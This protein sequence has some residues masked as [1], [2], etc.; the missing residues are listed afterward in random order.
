M[1]RSVFAPPGVP[2]DRV[3]AL[4]TALIETVKDPAYVADAKRLALDTTTWQTG[5]AVERVVNDAFS[6]SPAL[7]QKAKAAMDLP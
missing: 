3:A 2:P 6:L 7:I 4:R 1:G 5:E